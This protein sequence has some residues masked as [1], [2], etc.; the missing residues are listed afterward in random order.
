MVKWFKKIENIS[1][2]LII[3]VAFML[4]ASLFIWSHFSI[5]FQ[6]K[7]LLKKNVHAVDKFC[8]TVLNFTWFAMLHNPNKD[9]RDV[10][11]SMSEYNEIEKIRIFN[12]HGQVK[13]SNNSLEFDTF[14]KKTDI[15]CK[16]CHESD[17]PVIKSDIGDR[18]RII[19]Q[20]NGEHF[21]GII[22]PIFNG[23]DCTTSQ[24]HYHS[25]SSKLLGTLD[26]VVSLKDVKKEIKHRKNTSI[27]TAVYLFIILCITI[28]ICIFFLVTNPIKKLMTETDLIG[29]G[30]F[31]ID[32]STTIKNSDEIG[33]LSYAIHDMGAKIEAKQNELNKQKDM[34]QNLFNQ[35]PC[36][37][38]VQSKDYKL[39]EFNKEFAGTFNPQYGDYCYSAYKNLNKKCEDCPVERTFIDGESHFS[40]ESRI[41]KDGTSSH[42]FVKTAPLRDENGDV[43]AAMEMSIDI[44]R[45]IRLEEIVRE[46]EKKYQAIFK[47]IPN[48]VFIIDEKSFEIINCNHSAISTY[49]YEKDELESRPFGIFFEKEKDFQ[50]FIEKIKEPFHERLVN[51]T[52][53]KE[54]LNVNIWIRPADFSEKKVLL[55]TVVDITRSV[56]TEQQL[57]QAGK[58]ATLGEMATGV[59]HE[60]NQPLSV[61]KTASGF[62]NKKIRAKENIEEDILRIM[63]EEIES[64]VDRAAR[65]TSH[66]RLFGRKSE[67][68]KESVNIN[69]IIKR[70]LMIFNQQLKLREITVELE[71]SNTIPNVQVDPLRIEQVFINLLINAR[72]AIVKKF[73]NGISEPQLKKIMIET[74]CIDEKVQVKISDTGSGIPESNINKIFEPF[75]TTKEIGEGTGLGLSI[76]YGIIKESGGDISVTNNPETGVTFTITFKTPEALNGKNE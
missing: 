47:S 7:E 69:D 73:D 16:T 55:I 8:N 20:A 66:M 31:N 37:I 10:L 64:H 23:P 41:N 1:L 2:K 38:T 15:A 3:G 57:I 70:A 24:C 4:F 36:R 52:K 71:L 63:A 28:C 5:Q 72:D 51:I 60:L 67:L 75:F 12:T 48:P 32:D 35:V 19:K 9:M 61:I 59:A 25:K 50:T 39:I 13:F 14:A 74:K 11:K 33:K 76:S 30:E 43:I 22:N 17:V 45:R 65:I 53:K 68:S 21:L 29:K 42:W 54:S 56:R 18:T 27:L 62:I 44:S 26:V 58:M 34:Y 40:E 49:G 6:E 46:S